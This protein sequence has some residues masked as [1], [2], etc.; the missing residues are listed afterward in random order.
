MT[1]FSK[2]W[3]KMFETFLVRLWHHKVYVLSAK[4]VENGPKFS[5][6]SRRNDPQI[7]PLQVLYS[8]YTTKEENYSQ[9]L[10]SMTIIYLENRIY[11]F[12]LCGSTFHQ[13]LLS[14]T[15]KDPTLFREKLRQTI[16]THRILK[17]EFLDSQ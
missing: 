11:W 8:S 5:I 3:K 4:M 2:F 14:Y 12:K 6:K 17:Y 16:F 1:K 10:C 15:T 9:A 13:L 7:Y